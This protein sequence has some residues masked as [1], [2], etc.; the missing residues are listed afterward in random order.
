MSNARVRMAKSRGRRARNWRSGRLIDA[1]EARL[2]AAQQ[3]I[4][5]FL[6]RWLPADGAGLN[7]I[8]TRRTKTAPGI[9]AAIHCLSPFAG[10]TEPSGPRCTLSNMRMRQ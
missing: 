7:R 9:R 5:L 4:P 2:G 1:E 10:F 3:L 8:F 6:C